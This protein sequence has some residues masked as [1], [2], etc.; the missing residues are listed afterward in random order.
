MENSSGPRFLVALELGKSE[1]TLKVDRQSTLDTFSN[2]NFTVL[3][4]LLTFPLCS[5]RNWYVEKLS[6]LSTRKTTQPTSKRPRF[7]I[8]NAWPQGLFSLSAHMLP[9]YWG[10]LLST[11][12][13]SRVS[14]L[15]M[16]VNP[17]NPHCSCTK[18]NLN[19]CLLNGQTLFK[20]QYSTLMGVRGNG[21]FYIMLT[22][23]FI[24]R[25]F[26]KAI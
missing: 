14:K 16:C 10:S 26:W 2:L 1:G 9:P 11:C 21:H 7:W 24:D 8:Q 22:G 15:G 13:P 3:E 23:V 5:W 19:T 17:F 12:L 6:N 20:T 4:I 25:T 18:M